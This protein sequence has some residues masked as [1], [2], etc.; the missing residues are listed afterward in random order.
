MQKLL[1]SN[2]ISSTICFWKN[3]PAKYNKYAALFSHILEG[4]KLVDSF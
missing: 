4:L 3:V 1:F 2:C